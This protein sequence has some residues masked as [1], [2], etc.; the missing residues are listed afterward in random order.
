MMQNVPRYLRDRARKILT[1]IRHE[2]LYRYFR[3]IVWLGRYRHIAYR[4]ARFHRLKRDTAWVFGTELQLPEGRKEGIAEELLLYGVH[5]PAAT[6]YYQSLLQPGMTLIDVGTN[7]GYYLAVASAQ[8]KK[9]GRIIGIE[10]DPELY[11]IAAHNARGMASEITLLHAAVTDREG[12]ADFYPSEVSNWGSLRKDKSLKQLPPTRV[13]TLTLDILCDKLGIKPDVIRMD[14][15]GLEAC[16]LAGAE[17]SLDSRPILFIELHLCMLSKTDKELIAS[18]LSAY[19]R[20]VLL[21]RYYDWPYSLSIARRR[22]QWN[23]H[24]SELTNF[25]SRRDTPPVV[26]LFAV[27]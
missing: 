6:A 23:L 10:P 19:T 11:K 9:N 26:S 4:I 25:M 20:V 2:G 12:E 22:S 21:N 7:I 17:K 24:P 15:E 14:I 8:I 16:A 27:P 5:E 3:R 18:K 1:S 13:Q